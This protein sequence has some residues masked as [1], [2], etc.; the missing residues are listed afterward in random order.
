LLESGSA[1]HEPVGATVELGLQH[2]QQH[3]ELIL[4]DIKHALGMNPLRPSYREASLAGDRPPAA[5]VPALG[6]RA[7]PE[8]MASIGHEGEGFAFDN[9]G[10]RHRRF[11]RGF[12][13]AERPITCGEY[14]AFMAD[15]GYQRPE[16]WLSDGWHHR[17]LEGWEAPLYWERGTIAPVDWAVYTLG[18]LRPVDEHEP[19]VHVSYYEADAFARWAGARLPTEDEWERAARDVEVS[20]HFADTGRLH[21]GPASTGMFGDVWRW[22]QSSYA[23]Y[24]GYRPPTGALGEYNGKFMCNQ[25]VLR[26]GSCL[27]PAG[28][29]RGSYR[30]FFPPAARWQASGI[31]LARDA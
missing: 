22:T 9:E 28:H 19:V 21:P 3:Q 4:T 16:L 27:T 24:P 8:G 7:F 29:V 15:S 23:P 25:M 17:Q 2:E 31:L 26:G 20:G 12:E 10:P 18:G 30:N 11:L 13:L 6:F 14:L 5:A 1:A